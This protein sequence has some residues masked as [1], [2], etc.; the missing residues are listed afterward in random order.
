MSNARNLADLIAGNYPINLAPGSVETADLAANAVT[1]AKLATTLDLSGKTLTLPAGIVE[2]PTTSEVLTATAGMSVGEVGSY[3][4]LALA[5]LASTITAGT[6]YAGADLR[7]AVGVTGG[8]TENANGGN[9][10]F[11]AAPSG[12]WRA[13][14]SGTASAARY[15]MT[16]FVRIS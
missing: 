10:N 4:F 5:T 9:A 2:P 12:T 14:G 7:Y 1:A 3:A 15:P 6:T 13:L 16:L 11:G 8:T